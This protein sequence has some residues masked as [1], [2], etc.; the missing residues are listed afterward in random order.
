M[1]YTPQTWVDVE[2]G[3]TTALSAARLNYMEAGIAGATSGS[4]VGLI[5]L[6]AASGAFGNGVSNDTTKLQTAINAAGNSARLYLPA[7]VYLVDGLTLR[8]NQWLSGP[9]AAAYTGTGATTGAILRARTTTQTVAVLTVPEYARVSDIA[10]EALSTVNTPCVQPSAG[11]C[12]IERVTM[13]GGSA[14]FEGDYMGAMLL[15][16]CFIHDNDVGVRNIVDSMMTNCILNVNG[17]GLALLTGAN[18]NMIVG[19]KIEWNDAHG[20]TL[21]QAESNTFAGNVIDRSGLAGFSLIEAVHTSITG[22][23]VRRNGRLAAALPDE[24]AQITQQSC[25]GVLISGVSTMAFG[26]DDGG[27]Y[28]S[29]AVAVINTGGTDIAY[30]GCDFTGR[31]STVAAQNDDLSVRLSFSNCLGY[32]PTGTPAVREVTKEIVKLTTGTLAFGL[33]PLDTFTTGVP[34]TLT[35]ALRNPTTGDRALASV[36]LLVSREAGAATVTFGTLSNLLRTDFSVA[37]TALY[38]LTASV[39]TTGTVLTLSVQNTS[40][41]IDPAQVYARLV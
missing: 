10:V 11:L 23:I 33:E 27:G 28:V 25:T 39:N 14:G 21:Y 29:P 34:Y 38:R 16:A 4:G 30:S 26:D 22:G 20:V 8:P 24:N 3:G 17:E 15:S 36:P 32:S 5:D 19:N 41:A 31:T 1:A 40:S 18:D 37:G 2:D 6:K 13:S 12:T 35:V 9:S 7:G